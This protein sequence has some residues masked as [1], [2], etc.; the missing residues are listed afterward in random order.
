MPRA[1]FGEGAFDGVPDDPLL[2]TFAALIDDRP[3]T[4]FELAFESLP[5]AGS[6][7]VSVEG[8]DGLRGLVAKLVTREVEGAGRVGGCSMRWE[9][10]TGDALARHTADLEGV[11]SAA[12]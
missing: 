4:S 1:G 8:P 2:E 5:A 12:E 7:L 6:W 9:M 3:S 10:V 11:T